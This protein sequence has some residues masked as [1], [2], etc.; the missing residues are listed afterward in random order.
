MNRID[1]SLAVVESGLA[2]PV[3]DYVSNAGATS[4]SDVFVFKHNGASGIQLA[5]VT[6]VYTD[7]TKAT[8]VS[9]TKTV[10]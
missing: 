1:G 8:I 4:T 6:I 9:V 2:L 3:Y 7:D 10:P 5:T